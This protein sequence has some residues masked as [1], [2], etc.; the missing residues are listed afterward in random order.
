VKPERTERG[1]SPVSSDVDDSRTARFRPALARLPEPRSILTWI[2]VVRLG[3][4]A[5]LFTS[6]VWVWQRAEPSV[7]LGAALILVLAGIV[8]GASFWHTHLRRRVA[9][10]NFLYGQAIFD[11]VIVA[12]TVHLTGGA[13]SVFA[14]LFILVIWAAA[15]LLPF[16]GGLL[17]AMLASVLYVAS[18]VWSASGVLD[19]GVALQLLL[20]TSVA[21]LTGYLGDRLRQTGRALG[22]AEAQ[23]DLLRLDTTEI[24]DTINTGILTVDGAGRLVYMNPTASDLL[25]MPSRRWLGVPVLEALD[26]AA[27][28]LGRV[29]RRSQRERRPIARFETDAGFDGGFVLGVSTTL[30]E[31]E[32]EPATAV[33]AI[34]QDITEKLRLEQ[35]KRRAE[36]LE[37]LAELSASLA[38]E[39]KNPLASI[40]S[41]VEQLTDARIDAAD[42][43]VLGDLVVRES[44]RVSRLLAEFLDFARVEVSEPTAID[45]AA[46]ADHA[47]AVVRQH[48][49]GGDRVLR[50][51]APPADAPTQVV[52]AE[53]LLHRAVLNLILNAAQWAGPG[54]EV[55]VV[56]D[57]I[58]S[59]ML[60][61]SLGARDVV[62]LRVSDDGPGIPPDHIDHVFDPFFTNRPGGTGLGL[63]MVH[64]AAEAHGG[65]VFVES[66]AGGDH[67]GAVFTFCL[68][69]GSGS[70]PVRPPPA[71]L[72]AVRASMMETRA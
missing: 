39:I 31:R 58:R 3:V 53:D 52:G 28:G 61:P 32:D 16:V 13:S 59:D 12:W 2:Y 17:V 72:A 55:E 25:E 41:A 4:A 5:A 42:R 62:R 70:V 69:A 68:P 18:V 65:A 26:R 35:L 22:E 29:I 34:F 44:A 46:L 47:L 30:L 11:T 1:G 57:V 38:H 66:G 63:A 50:L 6:V 64:R 27:P 45:V 49:D 33:T 7:T 14:P 23:L 19:G 43:T 20:F 40:R 10:R 37:A 15:I 56:V 8:T 36:R 51:H 54:G 9:S 60:A 67:G 24:L 21:V 71:A 48:P